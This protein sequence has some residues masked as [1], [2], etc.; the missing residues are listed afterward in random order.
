MSA[1]L[2]KPRAKVASA[3][4]KTAVAVRKPETS[5]ADIRAWIVSAD[6]KLEMAYDAAEKGESVDVLLDHIC[7]SVMLEPVR[8]I[9]CEDL[10]QADAQR[11]YDSLFP[12][13]AC[14]QGAI[15]LA[16]GTVLQHALEEAFELLDTAQTALDPVNEAVRSLAE[17]DTERDEHSPDHPHA[18]PIAAPV[19]SERDDEDFDPYCLM[20]QARDVAEAAFHEGGSDAIWGLHSLI[21]QTVSKVSAVVEAENATDE[22]V[23]NDASA[24]LAGTLAVVHAVNNDTVDN[25]LLYGVA[26]LI[27]MAKWQIDTEIDRLARARLERGAA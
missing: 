7:H 18:A 9:H 27:R 3:P 16:D 25:P 11:V 6:E 4:A 8:I 23:R 1:V 20:L 2:D 19:E 15:K 26:S 13:L 17:G 14:I 10:T 21:E 24:D 12:A 5:I 22:D